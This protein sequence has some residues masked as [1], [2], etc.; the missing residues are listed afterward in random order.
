MTFLNECSARIRSVSL[1]EVCAF[2]AGALLTELN[3]DVTKATHYIQCELDWPLSWKF[4]LLDCVNRVPSGRS[5][6]LNGVAKLVLNPRQT[7]KRGIFQ[8]SQRL[9][10]AMD[11]NRFSSDR[12]G[13]VHSFRP[14][15]PSNGNTALVF[16]R[17][18]VFNGHFFFLTS[19]L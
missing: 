6:A 2:A 15:H 10:I 13:S 11:R 14:L 5:S 18:S 12:M 9:P 19:S 8:V 3:Q 1:S 16:L 4:S 17:S 7:L